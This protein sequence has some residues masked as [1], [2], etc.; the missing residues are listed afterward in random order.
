MNLKFS[1]NLLACLPS[2]A[3]LALAEPFLTLVFITGRLRTC[4][5][6]RLV[7]GSSSEE[8]DDD[9]EEPDEEPD[10][11]ELPDSS[12]THTQ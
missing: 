11:E 8:E 1:K 4:L 9:D 2:L 3:C 7:S 6:P 10:D 12:D 5:V